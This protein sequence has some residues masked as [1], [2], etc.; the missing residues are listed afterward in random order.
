MADTTPSAPVPP[1]RV[2]CIYSYDT[3]WAYRNGYETAYDQAMQ[4]RANVAELLLALADENDAWEQANDLYA[5][6]GSI[7]AD[8]R[9]DL[10]SRARA[11]AE[12]LNPQPKET[13]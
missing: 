4:E 1:Y 10:S 5:D 2:P 3:Y 8:W 12:K 6:A 13:L 9:D 11:A 7:R